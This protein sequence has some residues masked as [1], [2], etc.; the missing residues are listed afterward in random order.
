MFVKA[1][2]MSNSLMLGVHR[3]DVLEVSTVM[4]GPLVAVTVTVLLTARFCG[5]VGVGVAVVVAGPVEL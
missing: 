4:V 5:V 1:R 3:Y 2:M